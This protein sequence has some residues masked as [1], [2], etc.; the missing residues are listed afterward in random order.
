MV[1]FGA[2]FINMLQNMTKAMAPDT[3]EIN[4]IQEVDD[5]YGHNV[6][7]YPHSAV[8]Y[9]GRIQEVTRVPGTPDMVGSTMVVGNFI[10][11]L[12]ADAIVPQKAQI[13]PVYFDGNGNVST[14]GDI[15]Q[16]ENVYEDKQDK[17]SLSVYCYRIK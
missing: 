8:Y 9:Q 6:Q 13:V 17:L 3:L 10:I 1:A 7:T 4:P 2:S 15:Y 12:E 16:V 11:K 14:Y 5:G